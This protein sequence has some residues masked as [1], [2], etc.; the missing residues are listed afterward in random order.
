MNFSKNKIQGNAVK[1]KI[2]THNMGAINNNLGKKL[3]HHY[4]PG[5]SKFF[6]QRAS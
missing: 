1:K 5:V 3:W 4:K 6:L 2:H